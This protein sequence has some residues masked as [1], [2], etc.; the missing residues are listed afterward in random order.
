[1][2]TA[3]YINRRSF[4][5]WLPVFQ[6]NPP[7]KWLLLLLLLW[8][9]APYWIYRLDPTAAL[10][11][12]GIWSL[13]LLSILVFLILLLLSAYLF[14]HILKWLGLQGINNMVSQFRTLTLCQQYVFYWSSFALLL[15]T[16][17]GCL[18]AIC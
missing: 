17:I 13:I 3:L 2:M 8:F 18:I 4:R 16:A 10:P 6:L 1:M 7:I 14:G 5:S 11:D 15:L 9:A 12:A